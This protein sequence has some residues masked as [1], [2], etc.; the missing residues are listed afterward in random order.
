MVS[1]FGKI[2]TT[3]KRRKRKEKK[4]T[5]GTE[6]GTTQH[7]PNKQIKITKKMNRGK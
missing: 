3:K 4:G 2:K 7:P 5:R 1:I 6:E